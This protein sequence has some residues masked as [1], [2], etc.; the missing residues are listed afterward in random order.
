MAGITVIGDI[1]ADQH[2]GDDGLRDRIATQPVEAVH[3]PAGRFATGEQAVQPGRFA[4]MVGTHAAHRVMLRR[5]HRNRVFHRVDAEEVTADVLHFAQ[6]LVDVRRAQVADVEPEMFAIGGLHTLAGAHVFGHAARYHVAR[7]EFL[8]L[9]LVIRH[10][11]VAVLVEQQT[12]V[13]AAAFGDQ[14]AG[15][16]DGGR[17]ELHRFHVAQAGDP[18]FQR[19][20]RAH[21]FIDQGVGGNAPDAAVTAGRHHRGAR[22]IG[23]EFAADQVAHDRAMALLAIVNQRHRFHPLMH[24]NRFADHLIADRV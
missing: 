21:A 2:A 5:A 12:A 4:A 1:F 24:R 9:R 16:H 17:V 19:Q 14:N 18:G 13:A 6:V 15:R 23:A 10:E 3:V 7:G 20:R 8:L 22:Q 11:A